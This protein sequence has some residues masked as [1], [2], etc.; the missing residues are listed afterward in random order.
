MKSG[1][2]ELLAQTEPFTAYCFLG[3]QL[4]QHRHLL[5]VGAATRA[6]HLQDEWKLR[7]PRL[8]E[9]GPKAFLAD[10]SRPDVG[11]TVAVRTQACDRVVAVDDVD[12]AQLHD[13]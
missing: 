13:P 9:Q 4:L 3:R 2:K 11:V 7:E 1:R 5:G 10:L 12:A 6:G 8:V